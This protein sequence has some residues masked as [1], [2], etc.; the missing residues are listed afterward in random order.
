MQ[1][2]RNSHSVCA[3]DGKLYAIGG[4]PVNDANPRGIVHSSAEQYSPETDTWTNIAEMP[5]PRMFHTANAVDG[6]IYV[7]GGDKEGGQALR[8]VPILVYEGGE[9][10]IWSVRTSGR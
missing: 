2:P 5:F 10:V 1:E 3:A 8:S 6:K 9:S 7:I 4:R